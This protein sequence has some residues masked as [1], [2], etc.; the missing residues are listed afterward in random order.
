[1]ETCQRTAGLTKS[2]SSGGKRILPPHSNLVKMT[3]VALLYTGRVTSGRTSG[4]I[5]FLS[6]QS[7][8]NVSMPGCQMVF[9]SNAT[10]GVVATALTL[11][12]TWYQLL[13]L[14]NRWTQ[15]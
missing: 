15:K 1:M 5:L 4:K 8:N 11:K 9:I 2:T 6:S 14:E 12:S 3:S 7:C 10:N 13:L